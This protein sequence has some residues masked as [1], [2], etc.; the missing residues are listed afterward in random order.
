MTKKE[1]YKALFSTLRKRRSPEAHIAAARALGWVPGF[2]G[3]ASDRLALL[4]DLADYIRR[5][6]LAGHDRMIETIRSIRGSMMRFALLHDS[7][8][9]WWSC[10]RDAFQDY[11]RQHDEQHD[12]LHRNG[13]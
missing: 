10:D 2:F 4:L 9:S 12:G 13:A 8:W 11:L 3:S 1:Q 7:R 5:N 6:D